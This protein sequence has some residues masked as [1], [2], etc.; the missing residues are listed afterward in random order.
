MT[1]NDSLNCRHGKHQL[2]RARSQMEIEPDPCAQ[3]VNLNSIH[4]RQ[5]AGYNKT[6]T[7]RLHAGCSS[8]RFQFNLQ[9]R[10]TLAH[11]PVPGNEAWACM[12][13]Y[14]REIGKPHNI[15]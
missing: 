14:S 3:Q 4:S 8:C 7:V 1:S 10:T 6:S 11:G 9:T 2:E 13:G 15:P 12:Y 5:P